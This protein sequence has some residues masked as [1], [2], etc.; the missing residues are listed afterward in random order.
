[1]FQL[2]TTVIDQMNKN[3]DLHNIPETIQQ[4][5]DYSVDL[6]FDTFRCM[7]LLKVWNIFVDTWSIY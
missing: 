1:M 2:S 7:E 3:L 6:G 5:D 4:L